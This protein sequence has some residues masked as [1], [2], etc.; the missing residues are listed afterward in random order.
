M[1]SAP[2]MVASTS[3]AISSFQ[4]GKCHWPGSSVTP[5]RE[6][7]RLATMVRISVF[8]PVLAGHQLA[9]GVV[10]G[11]PWNSRSGPRIPLRAAGGGGAQGAVPGSPDAIAQAGELVR[12]Q[13]LGRRGRVTPAQQHPGVEERHRPRVVRGAISGREVVDDP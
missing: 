13:Q 6:V 2:D 3:L 12:P 10:R 11:H 4:Y 9:G 8:L 5:S 7:N 1:V